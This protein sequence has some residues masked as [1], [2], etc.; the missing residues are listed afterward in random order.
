[1]ENFS[2][3]SLTQT[4]RKIEKRGP[5]FVTYLSPVLLCVQ[6]AKLLQFLSCGKGIFPLTLSSVYVQNSKIRNKTIQ[7]R[8]IN[9]LHDWVRGRTHV[10]S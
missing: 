9:Y 1:M 10:T 5:L 4:Y 8:Q 3:V 7:F 6:C 2:S